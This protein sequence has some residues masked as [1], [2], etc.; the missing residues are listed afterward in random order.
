MRSPLRG[1]PAIQLDRGEPTRSLV[2]RK[3]FR[4]DTCGTTLAYSVHRDGRYALPRTP[5]VGR[6]GGRLRGHVSGRVGIES[7]AVQG[8]HRVVEGV[9]TGLTRRSAGEHGRDRAE[10]GVR[11]RRTDDG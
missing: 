5:L 11:A 4:L 10:G 9:R 7:Q 8:M 6:S 1:P 3:R 2:D